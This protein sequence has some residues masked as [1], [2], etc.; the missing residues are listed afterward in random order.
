MAMAWI[1]QLI[2]FHPT[3]PLCVMLNDSRTP[4]LSSPLVRA[5]ESIELQPKKRY[6]IG[7]GQIVKAQNFAFP[8][9]EG[10]QYLEVKSS[11]DVE[12]GSRYYIDS[13]NSWDYLFATDLDN[14][15]VGPAVDVGSMG[16]APGVNHSGWVLVQTQA[17]DIAL[18]NTWRQGAVRDNIL[19]DL[20]Y[21][22]WALKGGKM[23]AG[24]VQFGLEVVEAAG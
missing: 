13:R 19:K 17:G 12:F 9:K 23:V 20:D 1:E 2:N 5:D 16:D 21:I 7:S 8:W 6:H 10:G 15:P 11:D 14:Q 3:A 22:Q 18:F 4:R 24:I